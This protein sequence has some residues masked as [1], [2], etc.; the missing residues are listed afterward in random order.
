MAPRS[1]KKRCFVISPIGEE[2]SDIRSRSDKILRH[3]VRPVCNDL[4]YKAQRADE[5][6]HASSI[7]RKVMHELLTA[8]LVIADLTAR[9]PN[10]FYELAVRHFIGKPVV[11]LI[12]QTEDLPF[13]VSDVNTIRLDHQDL[14]SVHNAKERLSRFILAAE[15]DG[16]CTNPVTA[17]LES[18]NIQVRDEGKSAKTLVESFSDLADR[19][20]GELKDSKREREI[21][22]S[23][24]YQPSTVAIQPAAAP[25]VD[26]LSGLWDSN[27]GKV[28]LVQRG[29]DITGKYEYCASG[30]VG[31]LVGSI[32]EC[33]VVF[34]FRW[35]VRPEIWGVGYWD[36]RAGKLDGKWFYH[37]EADYTLQ[38]LIE[39]P[40]V[41]D[42]VPREVHTIE[43]REWIME[44][45]APF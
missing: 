40:E 25:T 35:I 24:L 3:I 31:E 36:F 43:E 26:D 13:D 2:G 11:Q 29:S 19:I 4:N 6:S 32:V 21:L 27:V 39:C 8:D 41:F 18:L 17:A 9:N 15:S 38:Q 33:R 10:V 30:W 42:K 44:R 22:W 14:D 1:P 23:K 45:I 5:I 7:S 12:D 28:K 20:I 37:D 34:R 16:K